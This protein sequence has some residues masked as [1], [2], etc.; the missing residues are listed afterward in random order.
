MSRFGP[1]PRDFF[2]GIYR[3]SPPWDI[4]AA[5][6][7]LLSLLD[8]FPPG[9][10][11][12]DVGCGSGDLAITLAHRGHRVLGVD[13]AERAIGQARE[14]AAALAPDVARRVEFAVADALRPSALGRDF[15]AVVDSGFFH[16]FEDDDRDRFA[17]ELARTLAP[18][19][20]YYLLA[21]AIEFDIPNT[22][23]RVDDAELRQRFSAERGWEVLALRAATF[24]SR[25]A[26][27][28]AIAACI[29]RRADPDAS[30]R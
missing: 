6:P 3:E 7:A 27:V 20:R 5:Q 13:F 10:P 26:P 2:D 1:E 17:A 30:P 22:P 28:P 12:L 21:F 4:G 14:K 9:D 11:I 24:E 29:E 19:G 15:A 18:G 25:I 16:L 8:E 23:R